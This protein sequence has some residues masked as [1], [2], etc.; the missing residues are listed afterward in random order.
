MQVS[1]I[2]NF[3]LTTTDIRGGKYGKLLERNKAEIELG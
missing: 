1:Y 2:F 3:F